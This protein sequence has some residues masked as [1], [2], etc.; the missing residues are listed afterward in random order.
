MLDVEYG[1]ASMFVLSLLKPFT[2]VI[3]H[4]LSVTWQQ[5]ADSLT[6]P[7]LVCSETAAVPPRSTSTICPNLFRNITPRNILGLCRLF[8]VLSEDA[9]LLF[10]LRD[11]CTEIMQTWKKTTTTL[12]Y[13]CHW[14]M[15]FSNSLFFFTPFSFSSLN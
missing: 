12:L 11:N 1:P 4:H 15:P 7:K 3:L 6:L 8:L 14:N 2:S 13:V 5:K 9:S 10:T